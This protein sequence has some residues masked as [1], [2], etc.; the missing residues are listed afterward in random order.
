MVRPFAFRGH[1]AKKSNMAIR[2]AAAIAFACVFLTGC[3]QFYYGFLVR[4][5]NDSGRTLTATSKIPGQE[6]QSCTIEPG[7]TYQMT[8]ASD[9]VLSDGRT[10]RNYKFENKGGAAT[11]KCAPLNAFSPDVET[12]K[13]T[14]DGSIYCIAD[15]TAQCQQ[16]NGF[17]LAP[18][19]NAVN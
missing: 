2:H 1:F 6:T 5:Q 4:L 14:T 16:P 8:V 18:S 12:W 15:N 7:E 10:I 9:L 17:P 11:L 13:I 19:A 3:D